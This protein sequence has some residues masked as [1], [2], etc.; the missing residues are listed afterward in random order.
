MQFLSAFRTF[1]VLIIA[2]HN[3]LRREGD[4]DNSKTKFLLK[5]KWCEGK[6]WG[7][8]LKEIIVPAISHQMQRVVALLF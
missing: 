7:L 6:P 5:K 4:L 8:A 2:V 1:F 3:I